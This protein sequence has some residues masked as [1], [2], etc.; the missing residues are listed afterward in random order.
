VLHEITLRAL[1]LRSA[2]N[3]GFGGANNLAI[4]QATGEYLFI[5]NNDT[6]LSSNV[7]EELMEPFLR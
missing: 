3:L 5:V 1:I 4:E 6:I 2:V 7:V